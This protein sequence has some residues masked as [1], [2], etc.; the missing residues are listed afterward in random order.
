[1]YL[2]VPLRDALFVVWLRR[3]DTSTYELFDA[4]LAESSK[5][6]NF[7]PASKACKIL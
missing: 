6:R 1:V 5:V 7:E 4:G 2:R 3:A